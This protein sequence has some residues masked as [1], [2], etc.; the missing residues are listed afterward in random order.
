M[1]MKLKSKFSSAI[2]RARTELGYTQDQVAEAVSISTRWYQR[3][4]SGAKFPSGTTMLRLALFLHID[5]EEFREEVD[6]VDPVPTVRRK[7][8]YR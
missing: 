6:L 1:S 8:V 5:I 7:Y 4:E 2:L 3:V